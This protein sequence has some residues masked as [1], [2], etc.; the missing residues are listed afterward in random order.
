MSIK[1]QDVISVLRFLN[2]LLKEYPDVDW[3]NVSIL[4]CPYREA[5]GH[6][7]VC[8]PVDQGIPVWG[9]ILIDRGVQFKSE[10]IHLKKYKDGDDSFLWAGYGEE[11]KK[12]VI[13]DM[14]DD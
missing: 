1:A 13:V 7:V 2:V 8:V 14:P 12:L 11:S 4:E 6:R 9:N 5:R 10:D 3:L